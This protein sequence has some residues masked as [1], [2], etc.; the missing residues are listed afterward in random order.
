MIYNLLF[1]S[2]LDSIL[3]FLCVEQS[4]IYENGSKIIIKIQFMKKTELFLIFS[5]I[6]SRQK[7]Q[8]LLIKFIPDNFN[9][10]TGWIVRLEKIV[11]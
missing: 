1:V 5:F 7:A 11:I 6:Y 8:I 3:L 10:H 4:R 9:F 2:C